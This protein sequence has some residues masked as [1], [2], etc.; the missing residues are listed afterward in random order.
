MPVGGPFPSSRLRLA[1][2]GAAVLALLF[3][4]LAPASPGR[5]H[6]RPAAGHRPGRI[7]SAVDGRTPGLA[8]GPPCAL[9]MLQYDNLVAT[10]RRRRQRQRGQP[11]PS[12]SVATNVTTNV[13]TLGGSRLGCSRRTRHPLAAPW[14]QR[15][16]AQGLG[17]TWCQE[18]CRDICRDTFAGRGHSK[19]SGMWQISAC[20]SCA[21]RSLRMLR[22]RSGEACG[23]GPGA[24]RPRPG[25]KCYKRRGPTI[26]KPGAG[27]GPRAAASPAP[28]TAVLFIRRPGRCG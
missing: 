11:L 3:I 12:P 28:G 15:P 6:F 25:G 19:I 5:G 7:V 10:P 22:H 24:C 1:Q 21:R 26:T 2:S 18:K 13:V 4:L 8:L 23:I 17:A 20:R 27:R 16:M 14:S 9:C